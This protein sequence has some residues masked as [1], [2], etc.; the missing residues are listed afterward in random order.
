MTELIYLK[1]YMYTDK[2]IWPITYDFQ[3]KGLTRIKRF[4]TSASKEML[5]EIQNDGILICL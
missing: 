2:Q 4:G 3:L 1:S 5:Q